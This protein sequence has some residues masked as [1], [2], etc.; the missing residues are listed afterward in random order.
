MYIRM[1]TATAP[2][3]PV[4]YL[5]VSKSSLV[6]AMSSVC[7]SDAATRSRRL[8]QTESLRGHFAA[9]QIVVLLFGCDSSA[10]LVLVLG[11]AAAPCTSMLGEVITDDDGACQPVARCQL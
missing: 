6:C 10:N 7:R 2:T 11:C 5:V 8:A 4:W 3:T 1:Q 9:S